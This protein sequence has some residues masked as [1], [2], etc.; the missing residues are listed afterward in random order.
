MERGL[1]SLLPAASHRRTLQELKVHDSAK[2]AATSYGK[3]S[4][5]PLQSS[6]WMSGPHLGPYRVFRNVMLNRNGSVTFFDQPQ[7]TTAVA[8]L[9]QRELLLP[10]VTIKRPSMLEFG[11]QRWE[12]PNPRSHAGCH[13]FIRV[14]HCRE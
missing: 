12:G 1:N 4:K 11:I 9:E 7:A 6:V 3:A 14:S 13:H 5:D 10:N 8:D 2:E